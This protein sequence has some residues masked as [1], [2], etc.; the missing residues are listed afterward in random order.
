MKLTCRVYRKLK[1][2]YGNIAKTLNP[3]RFRRSVSGLVERWVG[4]S[5]VSEETPQ[6][7]LEAARKNVKESLLVS[8]VAFV[9]SVLS[10]CIVLATEKGWL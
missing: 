5:Q 10:I 4:R 6:A 1:L 7:Y 3:V 8:L 2:I 9:L